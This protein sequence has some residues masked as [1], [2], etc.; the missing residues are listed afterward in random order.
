V[1]ISSGEYIVW[2]VERGGAVEV[3]VVA[4]NFENENELAMLWKR[5]F[6]NPFTYRAIAFCRQPTFSQSTLL[7]PASA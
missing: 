7:V 2:S 4:W 6:V 1:R 3:K 5:V